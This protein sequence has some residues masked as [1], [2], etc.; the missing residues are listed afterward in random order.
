MATSKTKV[1]FSIVTSETAELIV[2]ICFL[3]NDLKHTFG[4]AFI[5]NERNKMRCDGQI[6]QQMDTVLGSN[7]LSEFK[8]KLKDFIKMTDSFIGIY[9]A[10][11]SDFSEKQSIQLTLQKLLISLKQLQLKTTA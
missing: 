1:E 6:L 8:N 10:S 4:E 3:T 7:T 9:Q 2:N 5:P 11:E